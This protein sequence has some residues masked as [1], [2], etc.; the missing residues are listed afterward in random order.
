MHDTVRDSLQQVLSRALAD[1][2]FPGAFA[3]VGDRTRVH[4]EVSV[5]R[6]DWGSSARPDGDTLWDIASLTK[7]VGTTTAVMQLWQRGRVELDAW[8]G[9]YLDGFGG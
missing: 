8:V 7:V 5:G 4:A 9:R 1:S 3:V 6:L 2:A